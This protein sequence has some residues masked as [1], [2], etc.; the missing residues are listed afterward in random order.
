MHGTLETNS[1]RLQPGPKRL[2]KLWLANLRASSRRWWEARRARAAY[3]QLFDDRPVRTDP[4]TTFET[5][6]RSWR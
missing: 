4:S 6:V 2:P 5:T 3:R 1:T